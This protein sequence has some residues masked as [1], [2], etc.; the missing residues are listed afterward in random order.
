MSQCPF[1][2][3][4]KLPEPLYSN[5]HCQIIP[6]ISPL[7]PG[8]VLVI[9]YEHIEGIARCGE[10]IF[11]SVLDAVDMA[12]SRYDHWA[13]IFEHGALHD[14][15]A[16]SSI[17]HAHIHIIPGR[18]DLTGLIESSLSLKSIPLHYKQLNATFLKDKAYLFVQSDMSAMGAY[19]SVQSLPRQYLRA[20]LLRKLKRP[21][22]FDWEV[23]AGTGE[24][25]RMVEETI[26]LWK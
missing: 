8:H 2:D 12:L 25:K 19:Y 10:D 6:D 13:T 3:L 17:S 24:A 20:L 4:A 9:P 1:C 7:L 15:N 5:E 18:I 23:N 22:L 26:A 16:G 14:E 11:A 21:P